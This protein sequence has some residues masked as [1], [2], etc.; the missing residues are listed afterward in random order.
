MYDQAAAGDLPS[1]KFGG[2]RRF[3]RDDI[4]AWLAAH[5]EGGDPA[6]TTAEAATPPAARRH[7]A[8]G[9][10]RTVR[11]LA[12]GPRRAV[13]AEGRRPPIPRPLARPRRARALTHFRAQN[14]TPSGIVLELHRQAALGGAVPSAPQSHWASSWTAGSP[15]TQRAGQAVAPPTVSV[16]SCPT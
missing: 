4:D 5:R 16:Q 8:A 9:A 3:R 1:Y 6:A 14:V 13:P 15:A 11:G 12:D 10:G 7:C 2:T